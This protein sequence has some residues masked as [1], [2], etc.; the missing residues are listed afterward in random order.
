METTMEDVIKVLKA[1]CD[2]TRLRMLML[3][4]QEELCV[5]E[6]M[7]ILGMRQSRVSRHLNILR[8]AGLAKARRQGTWMF[9]H[10]AANESSDH[11]AQV[12]DVLKKWMENDE[13]VR[14]DLARLKECIADRGMDGHCPLPESI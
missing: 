12:V 10:S 7:Q 4:E 3:I 14:R 11:H 8:D 9:Y 5:C 2:E 6:V 13:T 1:L